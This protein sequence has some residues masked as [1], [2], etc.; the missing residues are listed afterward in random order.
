MIELRNEILELSPYPII[1]LQKKSYKGFFVEENPTCLLCED[2]ECTKT[3]RI[4][5]FFLKKCSYE[6]L[7]FKI[8]LNKKAYF[9]YGLPNSYT[10]L[11]RKDKK[12]YD[13]EKIY[14]RHLDAA[15]KWV[16]KTNEIQTKIENNLAEEKTS[17]ESNNSIFIHDIKKV[18]ST[19]LRKMENYITTNCENPRDY[20]MCLK[21]LDNNLLG[22]YKS[23]SLLE[24]QFS[25]VDYVA[26]PEAISYGEAEPIKI[27][28]AVDKLVRIF[29]SIAKNRI[30]II[31]TSH[32]ELYLR[33]SFMTLMFILID[34]ANKYSLKDQPIT[35]EVQDYN[36]ETFVSVTSYSPN[37][38][39][40]SKKKVFEK[41]HRENC[42]KKITPDGQGIGLYLAKKIAESL[43]TIINISC[44]TKTTNLNDI[45]YTEVKFKFTLTSLD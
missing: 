17:I 41:Y 42:A 14:F 45:E 11:P 26:N 34:N 3:K 2:K 43:K 5:D 8:T 18:Y 37:L 9:M 33:Q 20:D 32:N 10:D 19:I 44:S 16:L 13:K 27:Y 7:Y 28:K 21:N 22:V 6:L 31:G 38:N 40:N 1:D 29:Q 23:I 25:L 35:V 36:Y 30:N 12:K 39:N 4:Q 15:K 24:H